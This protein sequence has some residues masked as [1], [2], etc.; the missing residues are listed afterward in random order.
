M[1]WSKKILLFSSPYVSNFM[2]C[3][4]W[5][6]SNFQAATAKFSAQACTESRKGDGVTLYSPRGV[7]FL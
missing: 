2:N 6:P 1:N 4:M 3:V 7:F 5:P